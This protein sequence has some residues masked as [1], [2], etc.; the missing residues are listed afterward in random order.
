MIFQWDKPEF[1]IKL[2]VQA[3]DIQSIP[4]Q[5]GNFGIVLHAPI[6]K[7]ELNLLILMF[8]SYNDNYIEKNKKCIK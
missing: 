5:N 1:F 3:V 2:L 4:P 7:P 8:Y 6:T